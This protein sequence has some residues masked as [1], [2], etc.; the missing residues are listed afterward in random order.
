[1]SLRSPSG[2]PLLARVP[3]PA[4]RPQSDPNPS[5]RTVWS[6]T[7][8]ALLAAAVVS[9]LMLARQHPGSHF[10]KPRPQSTVYRPYFEVYLKYGLSASSAQET[11]VQSDQG[12]HLNNPG[13]H[14]LTHSLGY[15]R[16]GHR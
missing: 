2:R 7:P 11:V 4:R 14:S 16:A 5:R 1:M 9:C 6:S 13:T 3:R 8:Q 10:R 15:S 12:T